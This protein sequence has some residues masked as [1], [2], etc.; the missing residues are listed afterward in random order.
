M[1]SFD[2]ESKSE[3]NCKRGGGWGWGEGLW[4]RGGW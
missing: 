4:M 1:I 3:K 2:K